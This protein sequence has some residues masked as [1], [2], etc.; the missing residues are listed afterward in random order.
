MT[1]MFIHD[2]GEIACP[3]H[4]GSYAAA[5]LDHK[6]RAR[7]LHTPLGTWE[8]LSAADIDRLAEMGVAAACET[9]AARCRNTRGA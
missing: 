6:P 7:L 5:E 8:R 2:N 1:T 4:F 9:C 3:E